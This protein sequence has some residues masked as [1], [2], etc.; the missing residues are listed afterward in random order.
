MRCDGQERG[1]AVAGSATDELPGTVTADSSAH[2]DGQHHH[3]RRVSSFRSRGSSLSEGQQKAWDKSWSTYGRVAREADGSCPPLEPARWFG[4]TSPLILEI[5]CGTGTSTAAMALEEPQFDVLA[6]E[7][8]RKGLAQLLSAIDREGIENVRLIR[9]DALDVLEHL[10][11]S[12]SLTAARVFFPDPW[13][14]TRHHKRRLLQAGTVALL[15]D[16]LRPG[17]TLHVATDHA[18]Y[19]EHI[20]EVG[21]AEPTLHR[22]DVHDPSVPVSVRRPTTKFEGKAHTVGSTI[23]DFVWKRL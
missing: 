18:D 15:S 12:G 8:Y 6:V 4:R 19:A 23:N 7:V 11:P 13:P 1:C 5:G 9:G 20:A 3:T 17:G 16:R 10:L 21:D 22:L 2:A 14:K